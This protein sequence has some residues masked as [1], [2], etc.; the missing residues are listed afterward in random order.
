MFPEAERQEKA[1][2]A[3]PVSSSHIVSC[4]ARHDPVGQPATQT[5]K[6]VESKLMA[7]DG[8]VVMLDERQSLMTLCL[9]E[10]GLGSESF[11]SIFYSSSWCFECEIC[12]LFLLL[13]LGLA[14]V[15]APQLHVQY[16]LDGAEHLLVGLAL[17]TLHGT[18][19]G[20]LGV[21]AVGEVLL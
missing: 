2:V 1:K 12:R 8:N 13:K 19:Y 14:N 21:A 7:V 6:I 9:V 10:S 3:N 5:E 20:L 11:F 16:P 17:A 4:R 15:A 18:D